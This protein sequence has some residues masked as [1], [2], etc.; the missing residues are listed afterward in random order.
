VIVIV[1]VEARFEVGAEEQLAD[2]PGREFPVALDQW[3]RIAEMLREARG[4]VLQK[5][6][7]V[8]PLWLI[9]SNVTGA[10]IPFGWV[11]YRITLQTG[12][13]TSSYSVS[14]NLPLEALPAGG[15]MKV[16][17]LDL[18]A[19]D[20][21]KAEV[22]AVTATSPPEL[23]TMDAKPEA[24]LTYEPGPRDLRVVAYCPT[25]ASFSQ[26][27]QVTFDLP[28]EQAKVRFRHA[29][30][31][32]TRCI[33]RYHGLPGLLAVIDLPQRSV[34]L[35]LRTTRWKRQRLNHLPTHACLLRLLFVVVLSGSGLLALQELVSWPWPTSRVWP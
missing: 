4:V 20:S 31:R 12:L 11:S 3:L 22:T 15:E 30:A 10:T 13:S 16:G 35:L 27:A 1:G 18:D 21:V 7:V 14:G 25:G 8:R 32:E 17:M 29:S 2:D 34:D 19:W 33:T 23:P 26:P 28:Q 9:L 6:E 24:T 5:P